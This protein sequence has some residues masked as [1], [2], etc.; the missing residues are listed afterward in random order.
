MQLSQTRKCFYLSTNSPKCLQTQ[1][2]CVLKVP[3]ICQGRK[4]G[5]HW[6]FTCC[7]LHLVHLEASFILI[8]SNSIFFSQSCLLKQIHSLN[9]PPQFITTGHL[10]MLKGVVRNKKG[11]NY[12]SIQR[13]ISFHLFIHSISSW[14]FTDCWE[15]KNWIEGFIFNF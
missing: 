1:V 4:K 9:L 11:E 7:N 3:Q 12:I 8:F 6:H 14:N 15:D 13:T 2:N 10:Q 5:I